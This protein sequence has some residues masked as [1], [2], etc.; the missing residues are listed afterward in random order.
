MAYTT[1]DDPSL[2]FTSKLYTSTYSSGGGTGA[3]INVTLDATDDFAVDLVWIKCRSVGDNHLIADRVRG[4]NKNLHSNTADAET[5]NTDEVTAFGDDGFTVGNNDT[6]NRDGASSPYVAWCWKASGST[7][8]NTNG[9]NI[10]STV[11]A[12]TTSGFSIVSWTGDNS[13]SSTVGHGL[14]KTAEFVNIKNR[15]DGSD[16][17]TKHKDMQSNSIN[18]INNDSAPSNRV[19]ST[20]G[21][22]ADLSGTT[23]FGFIAGSAGV[24]SANGDSDAMIAYVWNS[25]QGF[26]KFGSYE[27]NGNA[28]GPFVYLGFKPA[29]LIYKPI[30]ATDNWE[31]HDNKRDTINPME[32]LLYA[33][34]SNAEGGPSGIT[35]RLDFLSNGFKILDSGGHINTSGNTYIYMAWAEAPFVNSS[36]V[37]CNAR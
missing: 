10:T 9:T 12:N 20:N 21:G 11:D 37:P 24:P 28:D 2:Y 13:G 33:N 18:E 22:I 36:G 16:W 30:D 15:T 1:I 3:T 6:V 19:G 8:A 14:G 35:D 25:V 29:F 5:T 7:A 34:L 4:A 23:T 32:T 27:G 17:Q 31:M 26:S